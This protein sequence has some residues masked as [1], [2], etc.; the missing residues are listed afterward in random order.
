MEPNAATAMPKLP[1]FSGKKFSSPSFAEWQ[2]R[3]IAQVREKGNQEALL[4][5]A[6]GLNAARTLAYQKADN[7]VYNTIISNLSGEALLFASQR[8]PIRD[9]TPVDAHL[10]FNLYQA[11]KAKFSGRLTEQEIFMLEM[12]ILTAKCEKNVLNFLQ[13]IQTHRFSFISKTTATAEGNF[14]PGQENCSSDT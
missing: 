6:E 1:S 13:F 2:M 3:V 10:G 5:I 9:D 7:S 14:A 4:P 12:K 11:L 8:F